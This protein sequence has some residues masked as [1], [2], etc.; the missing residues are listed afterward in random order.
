MDQDP[1]ESEMEIDSVVEASRQETGNGIQPISSQLEK[2]P[3]RQS[4]ALPPT[5][6]SIET[7]SAVK[8][9]AESNAVNNTQQLNGA[10]RRACA[11][12]KEPAQ[13]EILSEIHPQCI[14]KP[15]VQ[16]SIQS[17]G[18]SDKAPQITKGA[19]E[20]D[21]SAQPKQE[22]IS[23]AAEEKPLDVLVQPKP[24]MPLLSEWLRWKENQAHPCLMPHICIA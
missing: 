11:I 21:Q 13:S 5:D 7:G 23:E 9:T 22:E 1:Q 15:A 14:P 3:L 10:N 6:S 19:Q 18:E 17:R 20:L 16:Q 8:V 4:S 24:G 2:Q 12:D